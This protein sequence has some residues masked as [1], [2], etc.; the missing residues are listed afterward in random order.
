[1]AV[2]HGLALAVGRLRAIAERASNR[3]ADNLSAGVLNHDDPETVATGLPAYLLLLDGLIEGSPESAST[4]RSAARLYSAYAGNFIQDPAQARVVGTRL[5]L[6]AACAALQS[7]LAQP[8]S[9]PFGSVAGAYGR[10]GRKRRRPAVRCRDDLGRV[11]P[12]S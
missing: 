5:G 7:S 2:R 1:M 3:L 11:H 12:D 9:Q 10:C 8:W 6:C 4:L